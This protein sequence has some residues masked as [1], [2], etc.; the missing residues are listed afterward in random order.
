M[1]R[2]FAL[3]ILVLCLLS[4]LGVGAGGAL[5]QAED[6]GTLLLRMPAI[7]ADHLAFVYAGDLWLAE[8]DGSSPRRLTVHAGVE[9][10]PYFSPDGRWIA[11][12]GEYGG[13]DDVYVVSIDGGQPERLTWHPEDDT[14]RGWS[15]DGRVL[16]NSARLGFKGNIS[17][18]YLIGRGEGQP[19]PL[20]LPWGFRSCFS[21]DGSRLAYQQL[22]DPANGPWKRHRG[23]LMPPIW[24]L[25]L[26]TYEVEEIPPAGSNN[27]HPVWLG[28][29]VYFLSDREY[30]VNVFA[31][32]TASEASSGASHQAIRQLTQH[33]GYDVRW[34]NG[35]GDHLVYEQ[36]GRLHDL[37][38]VSGSTRPLVVHIDPDL[39]SAR[40]HW[41]PAGSYLQDG[42]LSP[43]GARALFSAR[44]EVVSVPASKGS[45]RNLS[46]APGSH[47][48]QP[49]WSPDGRYV[50]YLSDASG[51]YRLVIDD[52][53]GERPSRSLALSAEPTFY[54]QPVW[55]PDGGKILYTDK[56]RRIYVLDVETEGAAPIEVDQDGY[57]HP[58]RGLDPSWS[59]DGRWVTYTKRL[60]H[61][62]RAVFVYELASGERHQV[63]DGRSD[64]SHSVFS[65][66]GQYLYFTLS[67]E[68]GLNAAWLDMSSF[69]RPEKR[70]LY[71]AVLRQDAASPL[72]DESD[73]EPIHET[74]PAQDGDE[75]AGKEK[76][77]DS[78]PEVRIDFEN[79]D[80]RIVALPV[81]AGAYLDL[82]VAASGALFYRSSDRAAAT[83]ADNADYELL[84]FD[85]E[86]RD[87]ELFRGGV[88]GYSLS[89]D[90][91]KALLQLDSGGGWV[92]ADTA[93]PADNGD[94]LSLSG[95][96]LY[97]EP[98]AEWP[99]MLREAWRIHRDFFYDADMHG[100]DWPAMLARYEPF[101]E[102]VGH[103]SDL[104]YLLSEL[105]AELVVGHAYVSGGDLPGDNEPPVGLLGTDFERDGEHYR[106]VRILRGDTWN[107]QRAPLHEPGIEVREGDYLLAVDG[108]PLAAPSNPYSLFVGTANRLITLTVNDKPT[109]D[110]AR[111][112]RVRPL[113]SD[114]ALRMLDW[115]EANYRKVEELSDGRVAYVHVP[116][117]AEQGYSFFTRYYFSQLDREAAVIDE[118]FNSGGFV[119]DYIIDLLDRPLLSYW[120][121]RDGGVFHSP[122][123]SILGPK[124]M[125]IN[126]F[127]ASGG[128]ALPYMFRR[129]DLGKLIGKR[130]W[131]GLIGIFDYP[132]LID[133]GSVNS[134]RVAIF[135]PEGEWVVENQGV[136]PD[137]EV[138]LLPVDFMAGRDPQLEKAVE[139][140]LEELEANP[141]PV[142]TEPPPPSKRALQH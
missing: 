12:T 51:E 7:S 24:L 135:S 81:P 115:V 140:L 26:E 137:I 31:Y 39:P 25:D 2:C 30:T 59:P 20:P 46:N 84:R 16:F 86:K 131:G 92:I 107:N 65:R 109:L 114:N 99:Q 88:N 62:L 73:E 52:L 44:G 102:H 103:R 108:R 1:H 117:T 10:S 8:R 134:P 101:L 104:T 124:V 58:V 116:N 85:L 13:N 94:R 113:Y 75:A 123:G 82:Q 11:F 41:I 74:A 27:M 3:S 5:A 55:S 128:D 136:A 33:E 106:L 42:A 47:E 72:A 67:A 93:G 121:T 118:R 64:A 43:S 138:E 71:L 119:A 129:R 18:L 54:Y 53:S 139:V 4:L 100:L 29:T 111:Q 133:G 125:L 63:T 66:D 32:D 78:L 40:P 17:R 130:T 15:R 60:P 97:V 23:G 34:L 122:L 68:Y 21:P 96:Q 120:A 36:A 132:Q 37:D 70:G 28:D 77:A 87:S 56:H 50:A 127:A 9:N 76:T 126:Q 48:R 6:A 112:V 95:A 57:T 69:D 80:Q 89:A 61:H 49:A 105:A 98:R 91:K 38:L 79:L 83:V 19:Q 45:V 141:V 35:Y 90:G 110:G 14:V 22:P 142:R